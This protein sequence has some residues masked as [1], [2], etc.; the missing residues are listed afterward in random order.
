MGEARRIKE[1]WAARKAN[2]LEPEA[3]QKMRCWL[4]LMAAKD[5]LTEIDYSGTP[6]LDKEVKG[7]LKLWKQ[8][9]AAMQVRNRKEV[10]SGAVNEA[11][12]A[13][14]KMRHGRQWMD[15]NATDTERVTRWIAALV[16]AWH[17]TADV[18][19]ICRDVIADKPCWHDYY[20]RLE[21]FGVNVMDNNPEAGA[22]GVEL[23]MD[24]CPEMKK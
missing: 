12:S 16:A 23:Y 7:I 9:Q 19:C 4:A 15:K 20:N 2:R 11:A 1:I 22:I 5:V 18:V 3:R 6:E 14:E 8:C 10:S 21:A 13:Y 17:L 24:V